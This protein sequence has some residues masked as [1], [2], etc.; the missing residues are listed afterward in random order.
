M[1]RSSQRVRQEVKQTRDWLKENK[2]PLRIIAEK[3]HYRLIADVDFRIVVGLP[4]TA[5]AGGAPLPT[6]DS[7]L[8]AM[9]LR[10][11]LEYGNREFSSHEFAGHLGL[12]ERSVRRSLKKAV[13]AQLIIEGSRRATYRVGDL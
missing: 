8:R 10:A 7:A 5:R 11:E 4:T 13:S 3:D 9:V 12:S 2:V 6:I 1:I